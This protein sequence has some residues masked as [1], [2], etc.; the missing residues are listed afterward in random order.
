MKYIKI[1]YPE[2]KSDKEINDIY[3]KKQ[4]ELIEQG[5][6]IIG[7]APEEKIFIKIIGYRFYVE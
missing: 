3:L 4:K 1:I 2:G 6:K 7:G 5:Y